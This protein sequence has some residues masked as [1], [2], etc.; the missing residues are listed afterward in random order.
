MGQAAKDT[1]GEGERQRLRERFGAFDGQAGGRWDPANPGTARMVRERRGRLLQWMAEEH[2]LPLGDRTVLEIGCGVAHESEWLL[3][4]GA[5]PHRLW[6]VDLVPERL[7][8]A[9]ARVPQLQLAAADAARLPFAGASF[10]LLLIA[11]VFSSVLDPRLAAAMACEADR[12]LKP[13]GFLAWYDF[14]WRHPLNR[15][16]HG[17][18]RRQLKAWFPGYAGRLETVTLLPPL[19]RR[20]GRWTDSLYPLL[21]RLPFLRG[22][23]L[24]LLRKPTAG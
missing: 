23:W 21:A 14:R 16:A 5:L 3:S 2:C 7:R 12:V 13:G 15:A 17:I 22:H 11:A 8:L 9:R 24:G 1:G 4:Q 6:A 18:S 10:D 20:L 19:A